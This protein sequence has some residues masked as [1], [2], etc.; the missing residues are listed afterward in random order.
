MTPGRAYYMEH[1]APL[2]L[3]VHVIVHTSAAEHGPALL[4]LKRYK[5]CPEI[6]EALRLAGS[7]APKS[8]SE[9]CSEEYSNEEDHV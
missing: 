1:M 2:I 8:E 6:E 3:L 4:G 9:P 7:K 5:M